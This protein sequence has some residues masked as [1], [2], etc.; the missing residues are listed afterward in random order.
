M[1]L[2]QKNRKTIKEYTTTY[3]LADELEQVIPNAPKEW[4]ERTRTFLNQHVF[5][6]AIIGAKITFGNGYRLISENTK[7]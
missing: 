7:S 2:L 1:L 3:E 6:M 5:E 4:Y